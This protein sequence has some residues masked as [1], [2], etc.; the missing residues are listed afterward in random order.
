MGLKTIMNKLNQWTEEVLNDVDL[1]NYE[2]VKLHRIEYE[3]SSA[4]GKLHLHLVDVG[5]N[6]RDDLLT[7]RS[8][9]P[10]EIPDA[11]RQVVNFHAEEDFDPD[12]IYA[13]FKR[14][15]PPNFKLDIGWKDR[16]YCEEDFDPFA[17]EEEFA[18]TYIFYLRLKRPLK[19][20]EILAKALR[21]AFLEKQEVTESKL[22]KLYSVSEQHRI[23]TRRFIADILLDHPAEALEA[24]V[25]TGRS[26][27]S[28]PK[29]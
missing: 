12:E 20:S 16:P 23:L 1:V 17:D 24:L 4:E 29:E 25:A 3:W 7:F 14:Y 8:S 27:D 28:L 11:L 9:D 26:L 2:G 6:N 19:Q 21:I 13:V 18:T 22:A 5:G 15:A 10:N